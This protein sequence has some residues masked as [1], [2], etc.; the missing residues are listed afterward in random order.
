MRCRYCKVRLAP[1]R[2]LTD[3]EF[4][5]DDHRHAYAQEH[6]EAESSVP[7][8]ETTAG[9]IELQTNLGAAESAT[10][11]VPALAALPAEFT[12]DPVCV[13]SEVSVLQKLP[14]PDLL[15]PLD[16]A[17]QVFNTAEELPW[18][19]AN[20]LEFPGAPQLP[21]ADIEL[22]QIPYEPIPELPAG[23]VAEPEPIARPAAAFE[24][25]VADAAAEEY[26][27]APAYE[28]EE[29]S[30][31]QPL[32]GEAAEDLP[33]EEEESGAARSHPAREMAASWRWLST[34]WKSAPRDL[35]VVTVLIPLLM[36]VAL[37]PTVPKVKVALP[38]VSNGDVQ[39][40]Q[41]A[42]SE[43][44]KSL[45]QTISNRAAVAFADDFRSGLDAWESRSNLTRSWSYD[46]AGFVRPGPLALFKPSM[47]MTDYR[48]EFLGEL[49]QK[50]LGWVFRAQDLQNYY[51]MKLVVV[52]PGPLPLVHLVRYAVVNGKEVSRVDRPLPMT[53]RADMMYRILVDVHGDDFT[54]MTQGQVVD[55]W[56]DSRLRRGG[57]GFFCGRGERARLR[58]VEVSHQ[59]DA[60]GKLCA[61]LAPYGMEGRNGNIN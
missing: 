3:G 7:E 28:T 16:L 6:P 9:L 40:V 10:P 41:K 43:R 1:L 2:S 59:Y 56:S 52:R 46:A 5:C 15:L 31:F 25:T 30:S 53:V 12:P 26:R 57:V 44:W 54:V 39:Q 14:D 20:G 36:A 45:N 32:E 27:A 18:E 11:A 47:D 33:F 19:A 24:A 34:A 48:F 17:A 50:A 23:P 13:S 35:K 61:Y 29:G 21:V 8:P 4:C 60:L 38:K 22:A 55:F 58:W 42:F 37:S 49:D 51:A